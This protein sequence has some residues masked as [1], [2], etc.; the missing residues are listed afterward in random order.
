MTLFFPFSVRCTGFSLVVTVEVV[1]NQDGEM[2]TVGE[3]EEDRW[4]DSEEGW[5]WDE[6]QMDKIKNK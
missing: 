6:L 4:Y 3:W 5:G 1:G 2:E